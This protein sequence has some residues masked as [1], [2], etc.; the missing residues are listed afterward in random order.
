M[1]TI[2]EN[3]V[4]QFVA[5]NGLLKT[6]DAV[7]VAVS[8]GADSMALLY[9]LHSLNASRC[10]GTGRDLVV[11]HINHQLR[12]RL[13]DEDE[14]F[15]IQQAKALGFS[16]VIKRLPVAAFAAESKLSIETAARKL[17]IDALIAMAKKKGC[18][19]IATAHHKNDN[20]ETMIHRLL[21]GTG[22]RGLAGIWP[23]KQFEAG[24]TFVR[25]L[26]CVGR[27]QI[28][29]YLNE[30]KIMWRRDHTNDDQTFTRNFIRHNLLPVLQNQ[31]RDS[32]V[33]LLDVLSG[34]CRRFVDLLDQQVDRLWPQLVLKS[35]DN[36]IDL[37]PKVF[38][39]ALVP[40][41][42][43]I[44]RRALLA[45]GSGERD[46]TQEHYERVLRLAG[47]SRPNKSLSLPHGFVVR[48]GR[49]LVFEKIRRMGSLLPMRF[50]ALPIPGTVAFDSWKIE[51]Q[52]LDAKECD[53]QKFKSQKTQ[54]VEWFDFDKI[55]GTLTVRPRKS[56]DSFW[57]IGL[58]A[59]KKIGKFLTDAHIE[60]DLRKS[61]CV[62]G[63]SEKI[64]WLMP[65]RASEETK[66][67]P[68][69]KRI[70]QITCLP[71]NGI[72]P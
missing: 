6:A 36:R 1:P 9:V 45:I 53:I 3:A 62:I 54:Y 27:E 57:P 61:V 12:G 71:Q 33:E 56:G 66:I 43:E 59:P 22:W 49:T 70:L 68:A 32:L 15:V 65:L 37:D 30:S 19:Y 29:S 47:A 5:A 14:D 28:I 46:L 25:P 58:A 44:V 41:K 21:R 40:L 17:R 10:I 18:S 63:D 11:A 16:V 55:V 69:T 34:H 50:S 60:S 39:S 26:L 8:G 64:I 24:I 4:A 38:A 67:S 20:A 13:A 7:L 35:Q 52:L 31:S 48:S 42:P 23:A 2:F 72:T 51:T